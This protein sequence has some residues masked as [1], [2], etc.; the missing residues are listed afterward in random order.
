M[1][2]HTIHTSRTFLQHWLNMGL[3]FKLN[4]L[5]TIMVMV[6]FGLYFVEQLNMVEKLFALIISGKVPATNYVIQFEEILTFSIIG[7]SA[8]LTWST[9]SWINERRNANKLELRVLE[10]EPFSLNVRLV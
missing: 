10:S 2:V 8:A 1:S 3:A 4:Y 6:V 7:V 9:V 5:L